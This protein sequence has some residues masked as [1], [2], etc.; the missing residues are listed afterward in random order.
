MKRNRCADLGDLKRW[1]FRSRRRI[2]WCE[3]PHDCWLANLA[4]DG[5]RSQDR[6]KGRPVRPE[7]VGD[8]VIDVDRQHSDAK[9]PK[10]LTRLDL[11]DSLHRCCIY[12]CPC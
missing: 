11:F 5:R 2:G 3:F 8:A 10:M 1:I 7:L 12:L 6:E 9:D 4:R